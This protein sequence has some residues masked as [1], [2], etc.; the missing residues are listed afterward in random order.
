MGR[1]CGAGRAAAFSTIMLVPE[2]SSRNVG[3]SQWAGATQSHP[4]KRILTFPKE[5]Q[6]VGLKCL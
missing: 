3:L 5:T 2:T 6:M 1:E 4:R